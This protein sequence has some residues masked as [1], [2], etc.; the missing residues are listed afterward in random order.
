MIDKSENRAKGDRAEG[1][2][3]DYLHSL[4]YKIIKKNFHFGRVGEI[5]IIAEHGKCLVFIEVRS[6]YNEKNPDPIFSITRRKQS[7]I[8]KTAQGFLFINKIKN[9]DCRFDFITIEMWENPPEIN[10]IE[11]AF[12]A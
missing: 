12:T 4:G 6:R 1:I 7:S 2:T 3:A 9:K 10:H 8:V 11:N 5:D